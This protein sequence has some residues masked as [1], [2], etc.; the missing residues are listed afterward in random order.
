MRESASK[1]PPKRA[2]VIYAS[3]RQ[4]AR[5]FFAGRY[6]AILLLGAGAPPPWPVV[7]GCEM[8]LLG[9]VAVLVEVLLAP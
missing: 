7:L 1:C 8:V 5:R 4:A 3:D 6:R 2:F 9:P